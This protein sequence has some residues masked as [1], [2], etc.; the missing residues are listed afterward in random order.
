MRCRRADQCQDNAIIVPSESNFRL[1]TRYTSEHDRSGGEKEANSKS[2]ID[3]TLIGCVQ[4][5]L[6]QAVRW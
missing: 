3:R 1:A 4:I 5:S 6:R 2:Y